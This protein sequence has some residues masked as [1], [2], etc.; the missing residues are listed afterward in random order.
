MKKLTILLF[1]IMFCAMG[2][3]QEYQ[4]RSA[5]KSKTGGYI[6]EVEAFVKKDPKTTAIDIA[7]ESAVRGVMFRGVMS[8]NGFTDHKPL[9]QDPAVE[10]NK[11]T[12]FN[13]FF[14]E[15]LYKRYATLVGSSLSTIKNKKTKMYEIEAT[16]IVDKEA[17][18]KYLEE[19]DIINGFS[20]LW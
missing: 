10:Q 7:L 13:A 2:F 9:I 15:G 3:A 8:T 20:D 11:A 18:I 6:V 19:S 17:L 5:G 4:I 14:R 16:V 12:F 1:S